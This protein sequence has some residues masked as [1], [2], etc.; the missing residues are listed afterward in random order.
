MKKINRTLYVGFKGKS[1]TSSIL[2]KTISE[3]SFLLTNSF[4]GLQRDI[5]SLNGYYDCVMLFGIDKN[6][7]DAVRIE[8]VAEK[9]T[10][11]VSALNL[12]KISEQLDAIGVS[13]Y[14]SENPTHYLCNDAYWH[15]LQKFNGNVVLIHIP[16]IKNSNNNLIEKL[17][18]IFR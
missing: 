14:L 13:N 7:K 12:E 6:L 9:E 11:K 2:V 4:S 17:C 8:R 3:D 10:R 1:N 5:E 18:I 16:S 15:L